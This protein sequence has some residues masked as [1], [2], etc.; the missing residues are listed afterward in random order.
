M[1]DPPGI[2]MVT[3]ALATAGR[4]FTKA[5]GAPPISRLVVRKIAP[6]GA[7]D[8]SNVLESLN[9]G[10]LGRTARFYGGTSVACWTNSLMSNTVP[11]GLA[12]LDRVRPVSVV[13]RS[14]QRKVCMPPT[15]VRI[16]CLSAHI[17]LVCPVA[18]EL[19]AA[20]ARLV[21]PA[22]WPASLPAPPGRRC[23]KGAL[24][25]ITMVRHHNKGCNGVSRICS[26]R[27]ISGVSITSIV[28]VLRVSGHVVVHRV[29]G[30]PVNALGEHAPP[31]GHLV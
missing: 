15:P 16:P 2:T 26:P 20:P 11:Q 21:P 10:P 13:M 30:C 14:C 5:F 9:G 18:A 27:C 23:V 8:S 7:P 12:G 1:G 25:P 22:A 28:G 19:N 31:N 4:R 17:P 29:I 3:C 24:P 6:G